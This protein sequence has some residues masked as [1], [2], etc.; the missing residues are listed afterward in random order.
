MS[1]LVVVL[2][3]VI[4][5]EFGTRWY[6]AKKITEEYQAATENQVAEED[7]PHVKFG[8]VP[9][10]W[11]LLRGSLKQINVD[12]P[13]TLERTDTDV[14]GQPAITAHLEDVT[15]SQKPTAGVFKA[16]TTVPDQL[17]LIVL[18]NAVRE[19]S[20]FDR[21]GDVAIS[22]IT[23]HDAEDTIDAELAGGLGALT[24]HPHAQD[25]QLAID[26]VKA[27]VFGFELPEAARAGIEDAIRS[28]IEAVY[29]GG[30]DVTNVDVRDGEL[31]LSARGENV[32]LNQLAEDM[33]Q[34]DPSR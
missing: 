16:S 17:I 34:Y 28:Q 1:T 12:A 32:D 29:T 22:N 18:Q 19:Q 25:G 9:V 27:E 4:L 30:M 13:S 8:P 3:L 33:G 24:V 14:S 7:Q 15:P 10:T 5:A 11:G 21:L 6:M 20:G 26:T 2:L 23:T 31:T